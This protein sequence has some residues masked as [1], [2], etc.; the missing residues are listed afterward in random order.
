MRPRGGAVIFHKLHARLPAVWGGDTDGAMPTGS[1][2]SVGVVMS[3]AGPR[4]R[5]WRSAEWPES[6]HAR[7]RR[8]G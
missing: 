3:S 6:R 2:C 5:S 7:G 1:P 8:Y 4:Q